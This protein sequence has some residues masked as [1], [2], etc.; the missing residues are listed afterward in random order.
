[1][2][3]YQVHKR[4]KGADRRQEAAAQGL[5]EE[6]A[7]G[8]HVPNTGTRQLD[9]ALGSTDKAATADHCGLQPSRYGS[10]RGRGSCLPA[11]PAERQ[12]SATWH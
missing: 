10:E 7:D 9:K 2:F 12:P 11:P 3:F 5:H 6:L 4:Q 1:M 8:R